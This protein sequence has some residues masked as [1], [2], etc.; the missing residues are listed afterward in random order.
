MNN[1]TRIPFKQSCFFVTSAFA[2]HLN[3]IYKVE[4]VP[5]HLRDFVPQTPCQGFSWTPLREASIPIPSS[6][7]LNF[8]LY[9]ILN[10][11][12]SVY[13]RLELNFVFFSL[14]KGCF[15]MLWYCLKITKNCW[16]LGLRPRPHWGTS[17][18]QTPGFAP[19]A[20]NP[21]RYWLLRRWIWSFN[22]TS[23]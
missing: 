9:P 16:R 20:S 6:D 17:V 3:F 2:W 10:S 19:L 11:P 13:S 23:V 1:F 7:P 15:K 8:P 4:K 14:I 5:Q 21:I 12:L 18:P 22:Y